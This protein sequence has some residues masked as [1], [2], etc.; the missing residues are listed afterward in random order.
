VPNR[1]SV[2]PL[3]SAIFLATRW[4]RA[5]IE[6]T[7]VDVRR[8][9]QSGGRAGSLAGTQIPH[10]NLF[11]PRLLVGERPLSGVVTMD[12]TSARFERGTL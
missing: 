7:A 2:S 11:R 6:G 1:H 5:Q 3:F 8:E 9:V 10:E 12:A 4:P